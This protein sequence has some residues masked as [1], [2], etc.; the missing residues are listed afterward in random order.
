MKWRLILALTALV[1]LPLGALTWLG[2]RAAGE[3]YGR[4]EE[5]YRNLLRSK[6]AELDHQIG[7]VLEERRGAFRKLTDRE[8]WSEEEVRSLPRTNPWISHCFAQEPDGRVL[9]P[10]PDAPLSET[11][12]AFLLRTQNLFDQKVLLTP[13]TEQISGSGAV[14]K[15]PSRGLQPRMESLPD[16]WHA[17]YWD[18]DI[19]LLYWRRTADGGVIGIEPTRVRLLAD[20]IGALP[21]AGAGSD[22][23]L[24][25]SGGVVLADSQNRPLYRWGGPS[26]DARSL[27]TVPLSP[28]FHSWSLQFRAAPDFLQRNF[29][30]GLHLQVGAGLLAVGLALAGLAI[31]L[32]REHA[33]DLLEAQQR[34]SFVNQVSH[35][36]K[37]PLTNIRLF[38]ELL[39]ESLPADDPESRQRLEIIILESR[40]LSRMITNVLT[41]SKHRNGKMLLKPRVEVPDQIL[42]GVIEAFRPALVA[43]GLD[44]ELDLQVPRPMVLDPDLLEQIV[45]NLLSNVEKYAT[46]GKKCILASLSDETHLWVWVRDFGPGIP[47]EK[48]ELIFQPFTR[49]SDS[50]QEGV[51]GTGIG[52]SIARE[53]ARLHGGDVELVSA[54]SRDLVPAPMSENQSRGA[55][56]NPAF[57]PPVAAAVLAAESLSGAC[58][59]VTLAVPG[60]RKEGEP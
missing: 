20:I 34:V 4:I 60:E 47:S 27:L 16:G 18:Q 40:R 41:F 42:R 35:E 24:L 57:E 38:A 15:V 49:L 37:T 52:L 59:R 54:V 55:P 9:I 32:Y 48:A 6:L 12:R 2:F 44:L 58:F 51:A 26:S 8:A 3:E 5:T 46:H 7:L 39:G 43:K 28:P 30:G 17:W 50:V 53:L 22:D 11:T 29:Q 21:D 25:G 19:H 45:G 13:L 56:F 33:R 14:G 31:F 1:I 36:L 10:A 23:P